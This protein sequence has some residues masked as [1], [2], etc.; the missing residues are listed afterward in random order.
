MVLLQLI[1]I[2]PA[3]SK[4][5]NAEKKYANKLNKISKKNKTKNYNNFIHKIHKAGAS[6]KSK[7]L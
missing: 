2:L 3:L 1:W 5:M 6:K 7:F 4:S